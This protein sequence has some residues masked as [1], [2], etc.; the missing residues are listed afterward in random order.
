MVGTRCKCTLRCVSI[1]V[2]NILDEL[3]R[4]P[5]KIELQLILF[6]KIIYMKLENTSHPSL[7]SKLYIHTTDPK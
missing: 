3:M 4:K 5:R 7:L 1:A 2:L 6:F